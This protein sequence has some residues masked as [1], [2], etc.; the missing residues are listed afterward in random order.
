[1]KTC[2]QYREQAWNAL[3]IRWNAAALT[4]FFISVI[5]I[6]FNVPSSLSEVLGWAPKI[7]FS[8]S[9]VCTLVSILLIAPLQWA[10]ENAL[11]DVVRDNHTP[12]F[13]VTWDNFKREFAALVPSYVLVFLV[14]LGIGAITLGIGA[15]ILGF[16]Y[17][18]VPFV[19]HD[20]P[21]IAAVDALRTSRQIMKGHKGK[22]FVLYLSFIGWFLLGMIT[23]GIAFFWIQPYMYATEAAFYED[24]REPQIEG[25]I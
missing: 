13:S 2:K 11:L 15:I 20:N 19:I 12:V 14:I 5:A 9:G 10:N 24:I 7:A 25:A 4:L 22:L 17:A 6:I 8:V 18:M 16:A 1:M 23:L 21:D 3:Q